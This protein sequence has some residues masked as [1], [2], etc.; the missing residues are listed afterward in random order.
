MKHYCAI[1][2]P[3]RL[4]VRDEPTGQ[5]FYGS[6]QEWYA[7]RIQRLSGCGP[8]V[9]ANLLFYRQKQG[10]PPTKENL[11]YLMNR[12]WPFVTPTFQGIPNAQM[13]QEKINK[14][15]AA[16]ALSLSYHT[17]D[18]PQA[19]AERPGLPQV[20][21]FLCQGLQADSPV[22][23]L[24]LCNGKESRLDKWHWVTITAISYTE[25]KQQATLTIYDAGNQLEADLA[26]WLATTKRGGG[27]LYITS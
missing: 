1:Q 12:V 2:N 23:F 10:T 3:T 8:S 25:N 15:A 22:A 24:N 26:L 21:D 27:L 14:Y 13:L 4:Q 20:I 16:N 17:L 19:G 7:K 18:I 11:L 6:D 5:I 9:A